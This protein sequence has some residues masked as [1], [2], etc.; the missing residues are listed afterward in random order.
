MTMLMLKQNRC[1]SEKKATSALD[2]EAASIMLLKS[3]TNSPPIPHDHEPSCS[4]TRLF[5]VKLTVTLV[6]SKKALP[7]SST[8]CSRKNTNS[9][10]PTKSSL[11]CCVSSS[12]PQPTI[13]AR[14]DAK[15]SHNSRKICP[16][17]FSSKNKY[18]RC[19]QDPTNRGE[20]F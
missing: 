15:S 1:P 18:E 20:K 10:R 16:I 2:K 4:K 3:P 6:S 8:D 12:P 19:V 9:Q 17:I 13:S 7:L 11:R 5:C 14:I